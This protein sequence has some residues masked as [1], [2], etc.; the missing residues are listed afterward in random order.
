M[1][2]ERSDDV[3]L[4]GHFAAVLLSGGPVDPLI[5]GL[6][7]SRF[8]EQAFGYLLE[9]GPDR[10][11]QIGVHIQDPNERVRLDLIDILMLSRDSGAVPALERVLQDPEPAVARAAGRAI[12]RLRGISTPA[13]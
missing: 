13:R 12:V 5:D 8:R 1:A 11:Q 10:G 2:E 3:R 4:A 9:V 7:R 6:A